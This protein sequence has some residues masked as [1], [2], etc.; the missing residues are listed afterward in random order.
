M[1]TKLSMLGMFFPL[2]LIALLC[3][4]QVKAGDTTN[5][6]YLR[7]ENNYFIQDIANNHTLTTTFS[8]VTN[9]PD[10]VRWKVILDYP[11][12]PFQPATGL[13][14]DSLTGE[15]N[16]TPTKNG[17]Y[18]AII[19]ASLIGN[20]WLTI[21]ADLIISVADSA[22][23]VRCATIK[24]TVISEATKAPIPNINITAVDFIDINKYNLRAYYITTDSLGNYLLEVPKGNYNVYADG[25]GYIYKFYPDPDSID[26]PYVFTL[27]CT[28]VAT[29]N[30]QLQIDTM[31]NPDTL[32]SV[33]FNNYPENT[34][35]KTG[36]KFSWDAEAVD[37][38]DREVKYKLDE[39]PDGAIVNATTGLV[40]WTSTES[41]QFDFQLRAYLASNED[42][43][44]TVW[45]TVYVGDSSDFIPCAVI[46]GTVYPEGSNNPIQDAAIVAMRGNGLRDKWNMQT[47]YTTTDATGAYSINVPKGDYIIYAQAMGYFYQIYPE[48]DSTNE[49]KTFKIA[50]GDSLN[51]N[52]ILQKDTM[53]DK[54]TLYSV[55]FDNYPQDTWISVGTTFSWDA[56]AYDMYNNREV[57]F[58]L[59]EAPSGATVDNS[60]G[61]VQW[62]SS[63]SGQYY[64]V[65]R[66]YLA[67]NPNNYTTVGWTV[68]VGDS[69][70]F[71][72]CAV[73]DGYIKDKD[74]NPMMYGIVWAV[75]FDSSYIRFPGYFESFT[76]SNG[77]FNLEVPK[78]TYL[79]YTEG[80]TYMP[81]Y[82]DN[83]DNPQDATLITVA[84]NDTKTITITVKPYEIPKMFTISGR[85]T[86]A[87]T[88]DPLSAKVQIIPTDGQGYYMFYIVAETNDNG[89]YEMQVPENIDFKIYAI[90]N[91][92]GYNLKYYNNT[93]DWSDAETLNLTGDLNNINFQLNKR[94]TY[95][96]SISGEVSNDML[97][98]INAT[99]VAFR[100]FTN[101]QYSSESAFTANTDASVTGS[102]TFSNI[103]P[104]DYV[105]LAVPNDMSMAPGFYKENDFATLVWEDATVLSVGETT[106]LTSITIKLQK[107]D[108]VKGIAELKG[109]IGASGKALKD[110]G[111][112]PQ[113]NKGISGALVSLCKNNKIV[114]YTFSSNAGS[115]NI[116]KLSAGKYQ[117]RVSKVGYTSFLSSIELSSKLSDNQDHDIIL[118]PETN[119]G[120]VDN[121]LAQS[122]MNVYPNP[123]SSLITIE[124]AGKANS[125]VLSVYNIYGQGVV[126]ES[127]TLNEG[128]NRLSL[129]VSDFSTGSYIVRITS[130]GASAEKI[131]EVVR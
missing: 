74:G 108:S 49:P 32:Y 66:A 73:I 125:A 26:L 8:V 61:L 77:Y 51:I 16:W 48:Q 34:W 105:L 40:E 2:V 89:E 28:D 18:M 13:T 129:D 42:N 98:G 19:Q 64:F 44:T 62:T 7:F 24:G 122:D 99:V 106:T 109:R 104:D 45:W 23:L 37:I 85:V 114:G 86:D 121:S 69:S 3:A 78:G 21:Q 10:D 71:I 29:A 128:M 25:A 126:S 81:V 12:N 111:D 27:S 43:Y 92:P 5:Y 55:V 76:D 4:V 11:Y 97:A 87:S 56:D 72:P 120:V 30:F 14:I 53:P 90:A 123:A 70:D 113:G 22:D 118:Q 127:I 20:P 39:A 35:V 17:T 63:V 33:Y 50:C 103:I 1:K 60:T 9:K 117:M 95:N 84:C 115:Y 67:E 59:D 68:Y 110:N 75:S 102:F 46:T 54:D 96:N 31:P 101:T 91:D 82:Y 83:A 80:K 124:Y 47:Y 100:L 15:I 112:T 93:T 88:N 38:K 116:D 94:T 131:I 41:G 57:N 36:D 79:V 119:T 65:L 52:F 58:S 107:A 130:D 6:D